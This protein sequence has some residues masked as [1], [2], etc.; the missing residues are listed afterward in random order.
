MARLR[1]EDHVDNVAPYLLREQAEIS[2]G[3]RDHRLVILTT[4]R[5]P[6]AL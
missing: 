5:A 6:S 1:L 4:A 3:L 2:V